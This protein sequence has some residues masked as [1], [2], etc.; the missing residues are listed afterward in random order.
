MGK[1][2]MLLSMLAQPAWCHCLG[3][4]AALQGITTYCTPQRT[5]WV[6]I[7][8]G[9]LPRPGNAARLMHASSGHDILSLDIQREVAFA[10]KRTVVRA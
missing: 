4:T 8:L 5:A 2:A 10:G 7:L 6:C 3:R 9:T 1:C